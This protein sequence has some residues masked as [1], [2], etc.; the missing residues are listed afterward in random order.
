ML[1][2]IFLLVAIILFR[3]APWLGGPDAV[4]D[5]A[6][7][8]PLMGYALCGAV[9]FPKKMQQWFPSA[10]W[11]PVVAVLVTHGIIN[12]IAGQPFV[13]WSDPT[14]AITV[15]AIILVSAV[16]VSVKKKASL[17]VLLGTVSASTVLFYLVS[18]TV[19]FFVDQR[20]QFSFTGWWRA[21]T[22]GLPEY[23]PSWVFLVRGLA[24]NI[25]FTLLFYAVCRKS[26]RQSGTEPA[27]AE[28]ALAV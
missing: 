26:L 17:G 16:G 8:T 2:A 25:G 15:A 22:L 11:F 23:L 20:Y 24:G 9:F 27:A 13:R 18:N 7:Y 12:V 6:G 14:T 10:A 21:I 5:F 4:R 28:P 19:S 3:L 1:P